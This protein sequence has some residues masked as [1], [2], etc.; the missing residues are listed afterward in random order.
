MPVTKKTAD[1]IVLLGAQVIAELQR[2]IDSAVRLGTRGGE[3]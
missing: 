1:L 3:T 2:G